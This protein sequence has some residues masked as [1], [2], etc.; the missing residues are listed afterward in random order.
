[1]E[2]DPRL[3][4]VRRALTSRVLLTARPGDDPA[5]TLHVYS[6]P[7][8]WCLTFEPDERTC[9]RRDLAF[10]NVGGDGGGVARPLAGSRVA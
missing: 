6:R 4:N 9:R 5:V 3:A 10:D 8:D 1:M 2:T 7:H